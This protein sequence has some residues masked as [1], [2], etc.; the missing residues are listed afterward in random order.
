LGMKGIV[1]TLDAIVAFGMMVF[2]ISFLVFFR[3]ETSTPYLQ[4]QQLHSMSEDLLTVFTESKLSEVVSQGLLSTYLSNGILNDTDLDKQSIEIIGALWA[5]QKDQEAA[6]ITKD[7]LG[8]FVPKNMG[9]QLLIDND[10]IYNSSDTTRPDYSDSDVDISSARIVSGYEKYKPVSGFVSRA[11]ATKV[12][13][14]VTKIIPMNLVWG[15]Y[16]DPRYWF[17]GY[18]PEEIRNQNEWAMMEKNFT[19]PDDANIS[20]AYMQLALD[21]D[22]TRVYI[23]GYQVFDESGLRGVIRDLDIT[24]RL[25]PGLNTVRME[26]RN[27]GSDIAHFH[28]GSFIKLEYNTS[29]VISGTN[30]T[31]FESSLVRG[32]PAANEVIPFFVNSKINN[33][34]AFVEVKDINAFLLLTLNYK[35]I[36]SNPMKNVLLY[37]EYEQGT[38]CSS[39]SESECGN[40]QD[41]YWDSTPVNYTIFYDNFENWGSNDCEDNGLW[42]DC[43]DTSDSY[44]RRSTERNNGTYSLSLYDWDSDGFPSSEGLFENIDSTPY[45]DLYLTFW[46]R[47][48][49]LD[50]GEYGR[51]DAK[52]GT[53]SWVNIF[54]Q[55]PNQGWTEEQIDITDYINSQTQIGLHERSGSTSEIFYVDDMRLVGTSDGSC[56]NNNT[57]DVKHRTYDIVF[58]DTGTLINER[59]EQGT[60]LNSWFNSNITIDNIYNNVSNTLGIYADIRPPT[61]TTVEGSTDVDW[62]RLGMYANNGTA[63]HGSDY[64]SYI[65]ENSNVT[66]YHDIER[67]GLEYGRI[68]IT[69]V[70]DFDSPEKLCVEKDVWSCKDAEIN[71]TFNFS[72]DIILS[73]VIGTQSWG[74]MDNGYN[75]IWIWNEDEPEEDNIGLDTDTPPGT[76]S[77]LPVQY[78]ETNKINYVRVGDKDSGRYLNTDVSPLTG[79][80]RSLIEYSFLAPSQVSYGDV[81]ENET[82]AMEDAID[83]LKEV[84]GEDVTTIDISVESFSVSG[85]PYMWGPAEVRLRMWV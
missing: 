10:N 11:W 27:T 39:L 38:N 36:P 3:I 49:G 59:N 14:R 66:I 24:N 47:T 51:I 32:A 75:F 29:E 26:F 41:C 40:Y 7:I 22:Y 8:S 65:T 5:A 67:Y 31:V 42:T 45:T 30:K 76:F 85:V 81:F 48:T 28:P 71:M 15:E 53:D 84:M 50:S 20:Y 58:N 4:A 54:S 62:E 19:I 57:E 44:I 77:Y 23:N 73:R 64:Y 83:R 13:R 34:T 16:S 55:Q 21:N 56:K 2:I 82:A 46:F 78:F 33:V 43:I 18:S 6:N 79:N 25:D 9:Y 68:D 1:F 63:G 70:D 12:K 69:R 17:N 74:G 60:L 37:R 61:N 72:T 35:Y 80:V 52:N